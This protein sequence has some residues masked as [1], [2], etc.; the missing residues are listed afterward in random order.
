MS[1]STPFNAIGHWGHVNDLR[2]A[3]ENSDVVVSKG[4]VPVR[5]ESCMGHILA[6]LNTEGLEKPLM[7]RNEA[8]KELLRI[9]KENERIADAL[10]KR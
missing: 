7:V 1:M 9:A 10:R 6:V 2:T 8:L 4:N 3:G 5:L